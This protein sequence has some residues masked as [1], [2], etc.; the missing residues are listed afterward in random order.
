[1][2]SITIGSITKQIDDVSESWVI[3]QINRR[4]ADSVGAS[5]KIKI[6]HPSADLFLATPDV[7]RGGGGYRE[8]TATE[9]R[10]IDLWKLLRLDTLAIEP[11]NVVA[12]LGRVRNML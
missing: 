1:M 8:P 4:L 5:V 2:I 12:F 7:P 11:K 9:K 3:D 10:I 6:E